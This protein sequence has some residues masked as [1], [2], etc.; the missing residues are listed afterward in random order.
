MQRTKRGAKELGD[1]PR[2]ATLLLP[3]R[4]G[5]PAHCGDGNAPQLMGGGD[6][7]MAAMITAK[8]LSPVLER[9]LWKAL[10]LA[11]LPLIQ[12]ATLPRGMMRTPERLILT[13]PRS[14]C[15]HHLVLSICKSNEN[16]QFGDS[17]SQLRPKISQ[18]NGDGNSAASP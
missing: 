2:V 9:L 16:S 11:I 5:Q 15:V 14:M 8:L 10:N 4:D 17:N 7:P 1:A 18:F 6:E 12:V 3:N 13:L